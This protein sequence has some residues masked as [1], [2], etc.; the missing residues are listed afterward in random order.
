VPVIGTGT[1]Y[2]SPVFNVPRQY[3]YNFATHTDWTLESHVDNVFVFNDF[4]LYNDRIFIT[5]RAS[6]W[7]WTSN[8]YLMQTIVVEA[9]YHALPSTTPIPLPFTLTWVPSNASHQATVRLTHSAFSASYQWFP[10]PPVDEP[11]WQS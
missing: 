9:Y 8:S 11:Y 3:A 6:F 7:P 4:T 1:F 2:P 5:L 10:L